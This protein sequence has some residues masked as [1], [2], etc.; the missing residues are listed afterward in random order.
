M[1]WHCLQLP[2]SS[3]RQPRHARHLFCFF[4]KPPRSTPREVARTEE[5]RSKGSHM[6]S[7]RGLYK[8]SHLRN[9]QA[10]RRFPVPP[11][12]IMHA[13]AADVGYGGT[14]RYNTVAASDHRVCRRVAVFGQF[15][16]ER[17]RFFCESSAQSACF[18]TDTSQITCPTAEFRSCYF[19]TTI[20]LWW[21]F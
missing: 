18:S 4:G 14:L 11:N 13:D 16:I 6:D 3:V 20:N 5:N 8:D 21:R 7:S 10:W 15:K 12:F 1:S 2:Q 9:T 19:R 17:N